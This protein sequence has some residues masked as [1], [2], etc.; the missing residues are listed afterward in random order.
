VHG[1]PGGGFLE[2]VYENIPAIDLA[3]RGIFFAAGA[4]AGAGDLRRHPVG[5]YYA[6][7]V[8]DERV[9]CELKAIESLT[10]RHDARLVN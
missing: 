2:K 6:N 5:E 4:G 3:K 1:K 9:A 10:R 8:V 7:P